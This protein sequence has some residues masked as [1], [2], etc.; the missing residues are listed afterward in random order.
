MKL[1]LVLSKLIKRKPTLFLLLILSVIFILYFDGVLDKE[2]MNMHLWRQTDCLSLTRNYANGAMF[3][4]PQLDILLADDL[5]TG[6]SAGEFP[7]LYYIIGKFWSWYGESILFYRLL[8]LFILICGLIAYFRILLFLKVH[9]LLVYTL[10]LLLATSP[11]FLIYGVSF[12]T[13]V[14]ALCFSL[15][16]IYFFTK[17]TQSKLIKYAVYAFLFFALAGLI[18]ISSLILFINLG[19]LFLLELIGVNLLKK[20]RLFPNPKVAFFGFCF[21]IFTIF[22]WYYYAKIFND[23]HNFKYT[24]NHVYPIWLMD[25]NSYS[26]YFTNI[27]LYILPIFLN[28]TALLLT[29][30]IF[31]I[32]LFL[33]KRIPLALYISNILVFCGALIYFLLWAPLFEVHDYYWVPILNSVLVTWAVFAVFIKKISVNRIWSH[34]SSSLLILFLL[35]NFGYAYNMV[36]LKTK[37]ASGD[38]PFVNHEELKKYMTWLNYDV[39]ANKWRYKRIQNELLASGVQ[40]N[41]KVI[42]LSDHSFSIS[43]YFL[44][45]QGW[46][47][48]INIQT[49][50]QIN[51]LISKGAKYLF[52]ENEDTK[53]DESFIEPFL[54]NKVGEFERIMVFKLQ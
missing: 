43:L 36:G 34:V 16:G 46:T 53:K 32:N 7:I 17:H 9:L 39:D 24:F 3:F 37:A 27:R 28:N 40:L 54:N 31:V 26:N 11:V 38:F 20:R 2:P 5:T 19:V 4:E 30:I 49:S 50:E 6:K 22:S 14:P 35:F 23:Q 33:V 42:C 29:L 51:E 44:N 47:N 41:D 52:I 25:N 8:Y 1:V 13:D 15:I 21:V 12:L 10:T 48:F 18:K 45:R